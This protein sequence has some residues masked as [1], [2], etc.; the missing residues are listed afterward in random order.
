MKLQFENLLQFY[1]LV[2]ADMHD[3]DTRSETPSLYVSH[4]KVCNPPIPSLKR[5]LSLPLNPTLKVPLL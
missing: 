2:S 4:T 5:L 1:F 3:A